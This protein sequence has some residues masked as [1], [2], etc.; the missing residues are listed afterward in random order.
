MGYEKPVVISVEDAAEGIYMS[1]GSVIEETEDATCWTLTTE[2]TQTIPHEG[3]ANFRIKAEHS[4][5]AIHISQ[6]TTITL[7]FNRPITNANFEGFDVKVN[8]ATVVLTRESHGNSYNS[9]DNFNTLLETWS[10]DADLLQIIS[11][12]IICTK[13]PNVQGGFN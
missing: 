13:T 5:S 9:A 8:G 4:N 2:K 6:K 7:V 10:E 12:S 3:K 1:S 11:S